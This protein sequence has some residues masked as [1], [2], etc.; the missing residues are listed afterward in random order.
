M[1]AVEAILLGEAVGVPSLLAVVSSTS[2][3]ERCLGCPQGT[4]QKDGQL[5]ASNPSISLEWKR[6]GRRKVTCNELRTRDGKQ[7]Q[8]LSN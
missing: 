2:S 8:T 3:D 6:R 1:E 4:F 5:F 7:W